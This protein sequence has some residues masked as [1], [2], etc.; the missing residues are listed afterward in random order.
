MF[1]KVFLLLCFLQLSSACGVWFDVGHACVGTRDNSF[2]ELTYNGPSSFVGAVKLVHTSGYVSNSAA[3]KG[4]YWGGNTVTAL[5][6]LITDDLNRIVYPS[7]RVTTVSSNGW[8]KLPRY[9]GVSPNLVFSDTGAPQYFE[10]G[11]KIRIWYGEDWSG[12][13]E[14]D[15]HGKACMR[16]YFH[17]TGC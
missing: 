7:T 14:S 4:S 6:M 3:K 13:T 16:V 15:N 11:N 12:F 10:K 8:Y 17:L 5:A 1:H 2:H 9:T